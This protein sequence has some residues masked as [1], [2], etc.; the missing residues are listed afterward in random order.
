MNLYLK[1]L[2]LLAAG[3]ALLAAVPAQAAVT[4]TGTGTGTTLTTSGASGGSATIHFDGFGG[5]PAT[6][7]GGL[8]SKLTLTFSSLIGNTATF[9]YLIENTSSTP[10]TASRIPLFGFNSNPDIIS[11]VA[12]GIYDAPNVSP[13]GTVP[14]F[15]A[16][17]F[18]VR[19]V[20]GNNCSGGAGKGITQGTSVSGSL[21]LTFA[22]A[23]ATV[24]LTNFFVRYQSV[25]GAANGAGSAVGRPTA[26]VPE[27]AAWMTMLL[28]FGG[29]GLAMRKR[30]GAPQTRVRFI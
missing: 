22:V 9:A 3:P 19:A 30:N 13:N 5:D 16:A 10:I 24:Q 2:V 15:G 7:I 1:T 23:P 28:G 25:A 20:V 4:L 8:T 14:N 21:A 18:C 26:P 6:V 29:I 17:E 11:A 27:P 12:T